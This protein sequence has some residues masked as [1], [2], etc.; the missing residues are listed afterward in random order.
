VCLFTHHFE[1]LRVRLVVR[2]PQF[3]NQ[4]YRA[5]RNKNVLMYAFN[6]RKQEKSTKLQLVST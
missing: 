1:C 2:V 4:W 6:L 3:G 5:F